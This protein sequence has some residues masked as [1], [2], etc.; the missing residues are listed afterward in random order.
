MTRG[1]TIGQVAAFAGVTVKTVRHYHR[2]GLVDEPRRDLSGYRRYGSS[3]LLRLAQVRTL[4]EAGVPL[5]EIGALLDADPEKFAAEVA[6]VKQQLTD[7]IREL[8]ARRDKLDRLATGNGLL[9][10]DR[11]CAILERAA[12]LG[13]AAN[14]IET[15]REALILAKAVVPDFDDFLTKVEHTLDDARYV[16]LLKRSWEAGAWE[17]DDPRVAELAKAIT[18]YLLANRKQLAIPSSLEGLTD[19]GTRY[20]LIN[21][22]RTE[23][24]PTWTRLSALIDANLRAAGVNI[25][26]GHARALSFEGTRVRR[27]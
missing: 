25:A 17:P 14:H 21:D 26:P 18:K 4:A 12:K 7:R 15:S 1:L 13:F 3:E 22:F 23:V 9:L 24:A 5:A 27:R 19:A 20:G 11:A 6:D 16:A 10:P 8:R 2:L